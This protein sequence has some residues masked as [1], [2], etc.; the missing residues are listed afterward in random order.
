MRSIRNATGI[1]P[2]EDR[3]NRDCPR[4]PDA[5]RRPSNRALQS[6]ILTQEPFLAI[7]VDPTRT[8]AAGRVEIGA[9]R[10][11]PKVCGCGRATSGTVVCVSAGFAPKRRVADDV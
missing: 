6:P 1:A 10:T 3:L 9:F 11:Y 4:S 5:R 7:V 8:C 2:A